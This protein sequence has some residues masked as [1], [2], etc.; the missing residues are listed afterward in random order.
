MGQP[1]LLLS[2]IIQVKNQL[3]NQI[4]NEA[5]SINLK[6]FDQEQNH[7]DRQNTPDLLRKIKSRLI[8]PQ[9]VVE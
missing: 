1:Q 9:I 6:V 5:C 8:K 4:E 3:I 7:Q 2:G